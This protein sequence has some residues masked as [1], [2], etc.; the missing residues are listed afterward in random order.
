M[1]R[2]IIPLILL[3]LIAISSLKVFAQSE[4]G[5]GDVD[6][7]NDGRGWSFGLNVGV[8]YP[9]KNTANYYNGS[10]SNENK[11]A[12]VMSNYTWYNEI[13]YALG[14]HDS[15]SVT[16]PENMH[17]NLAMQPGLYAQY[18]FNPQMALV[19]EF[20]YM[21]LKAND[22]ITIDVDPPQDYLGNHD[23]RLFPMRGVEERVYAN[24]GIKRSFPKTDKLTW[25][26]TGG[27][28]VNST[29]VKKSSF[30]VE[31]I[32][33]VQKEYSM[34]N[35]YGN[36]QFI[37]NSNMQTFNV[38]QGGIGFGLFGGGGASLKFANSVVIEPGITAHWLMV[39][40]EHYR[41]MNPGIGAYLRFMF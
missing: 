21:K 3:Q 33:R 25:F 16:G 36:N 9:S 32:N 14:A 12:F 17:Y 35:V 30:F 31:D 18:S 10:S 11:T 29:K 39:K 19:I 5:I 23:L 27:V 1:K 34:I 15:I 2:L 4:P 22:A 40:L 26:F 13:F 41:N 7:S 6:F 8:Y 20:N 38:Y 37:P 24:I 28:N